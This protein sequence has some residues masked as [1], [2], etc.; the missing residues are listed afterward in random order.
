MAGPG[1]TRSNTMKAVLKASSSSLRRPRDRRTRVCVVV[2]RAD[3]AHLASWFGRSTALPPVAIRPW[4]RRH[5]RRPHRAKRRWGIFVP[6]L[7]RTRRAHA[8]RGRV[9]DRCGDRLERPQDVRLAARRAA[10]GK[11][12]FCTRAS[13][14]VPCRRERW[15]RLRECSASM[16]RCAWPVRYPSSG[17]HGPLRHQ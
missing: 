9:T 17:R 3:H 1:C 8:E 12:S 2:S 4:A 13:T 6:A 15:D 16:S 5:Q 11:N 7:A 14:R 10:G